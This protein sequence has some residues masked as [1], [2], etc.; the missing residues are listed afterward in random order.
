LDEKASKRMPFF[1]EKMRQLLTL[2][3]DQEAEIQRFILSWMGAAISAAEWLGCGN[4]AAGLC[5]GLLGFRG[6]KS[7]N[8]QKQMSYRAPTVQ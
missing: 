2:P 7:T 5:D 6:R 1:S 8:Y 4:L 3:K